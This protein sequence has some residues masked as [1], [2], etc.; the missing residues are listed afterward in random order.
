MYN[1]QNRSGATSAPQPEHEALCLR[2]RQKT[3]EFKKAYIILKVVKV[4]SLWEY[5]LLACE[6]VAI[7]V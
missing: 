2:Q 3:D 7:L 6:E 5:A 4:L 1:C